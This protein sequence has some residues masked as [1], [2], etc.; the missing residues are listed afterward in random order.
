MHKF[1]EFFQFK[2]FNLKLQ[3]KKH[4]NDW[5]SQNHSRNVESLCVMRLTK[6]NNMLLRRSTPLKL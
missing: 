5:E 6:I 1:N 3:L 4:E 2:F